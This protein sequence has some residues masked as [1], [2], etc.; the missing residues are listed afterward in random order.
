MKKEHDFCNG[1]KNFGAGR[2]CGKVRRHEGGGIGEREV[3]DS[4]ARERK[5]SQPYIMA[6]NFSFC[7]CDADKGNLILCLSLA[8]FFCHSSQPRDLVFLSAALF[9]AFL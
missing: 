2:W 1:N 7:S 6:A 8:Y 3:Q 4:N 9:G 5:Q